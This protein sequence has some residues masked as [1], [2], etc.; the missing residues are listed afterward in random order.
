MTNEVRIAFCEH[1]KKH[2]SL[3]QADLI[4]W[5]QDTHN[6]SV[7]QGTISLTLKCSAEILAKKEDVNRATKRQRTVKYPLMETALYQWFLTYQDQVNMSDDLTKEKVTYFLT[8]LYPGHEAF[9]FSNGWLEAFK[10]RRSIKSYCRF[11]ESGSANMVVIEE[12][13]LQIRLTLDQYERRD[14]YNMDETGLFYRMQ[15]SVARY[16]MPTAKPSTYFH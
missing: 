2:P 13:L 16:C 15:V 6:V 14:I 12:S 8:E 9:E 4:T 11:G 10:N 3:T 1:K 5:L 7:S